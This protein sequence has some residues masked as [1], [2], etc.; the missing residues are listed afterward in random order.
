MAKTQWANGDFIRPS[1]L[2][3]WWGNNAGSGHSHDGLDSDGSVPKIQL[4]GAAEVQGLLP[5]SN[6]ASNIPSSKL[7]DYSDGT[8]D[9]KITTDYLTVEQTAT[10]DYMIYS[11]T[12][13]IHVA[14]IFGTSNSTDLE[15]SPDSSWPAELLSTNAKY[16]HTFVSD[17]NLIHPGLIY[18]PTAGHGT[19]NAICRI[20]DTSYVDDGWTNSGTK[21]LVENTIMHFKD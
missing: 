15:I 16:C 20:Y 1:D 10:W 4:T 14:D 11:N 2:Y 13:I 8:V 3:T 19:D 12:V 21:G 17:N 5:Y 9:V 6:L 7:A 18:L